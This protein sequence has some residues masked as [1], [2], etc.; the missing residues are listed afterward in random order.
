MVSAVE[1]VLGL[2]LVIALASFANHEPNID[3][4]EH[5]NRSVVCLG[6]Q[7]SFLVIEISLVS[8]RA[9]LRN[10]QLPCQSLIWNLGQ[11]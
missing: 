11:I 4:N 9:A 5:L 10:Q 7:V 1:N 8:G 2:T 6:Y 3:H